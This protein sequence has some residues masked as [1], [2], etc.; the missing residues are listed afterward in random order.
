MLTGGCYCGRVRYESAAIPFHETICHCADCR[1]IAGAPTVAWFTLPRAALRF[2]AEAP[3]GFRSSPSV[4]R[5]FCGTCGTTLT[6]ERDDLPEETDVTIA[7]LDDPD[8]VPPMD[9]T[10]TSGKLAWDVI[11]DGRPI[12]TEES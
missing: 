5:R 6:F 7:S 10:L 12:R 2:T 8:A 11:C 3:T 4:R 9:H 1:R